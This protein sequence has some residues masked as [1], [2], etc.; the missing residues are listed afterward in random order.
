MLKKSSL[1][2]IIL[3]CILS[4]TLFAQEIDL[5]EKA[6]QAKWGRGVWA[7]AAIVP[8]REV[9]FLRDTGGGYAQSL[10][11]TEWNVAMVAGVA[12]ARSTSTCGLSLMA[13]SNASRAPS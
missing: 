2:S 7:N 8:S 11:F 9:A 5:I 10:P 6:P 4:M 12:R 1:F 3:L 13:R